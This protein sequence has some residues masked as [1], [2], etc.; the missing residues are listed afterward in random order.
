MLFP[1]IFGKIAIQK[2]RNKGKHFIVTTAVPVSIATT[3]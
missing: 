1:L 2:K 3:A